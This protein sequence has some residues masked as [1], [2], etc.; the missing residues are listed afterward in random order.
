M[1]LATAVCFAMKYRVIGLDIDGGRVSALSAGKTTIHEKGLERLLRQGLSR[2]L[3]SFSSS[4]EE[5]EDA[6]F[7]FIA[8]GTPGVGDG[9]IDLSQVK[10]AS[11][12]IGDAL[13]TNTQRPVIVLK[14]TVIPGTMSD[15]VKPILE[16][17][18]GKT[19]GIGFGLCSNPEFLREGSAIGDT[20]KPDRII[21]G[22]FDKLSSR[23]MNAL[24]RGFYGKAARIIEVTPEE[25]ELIKYASNSFLATKVSFINFIA[26]MTEQIPGTD[27]KRVAEGMG[28]DPRIGRLFLEAGPG[29]GGSCFPKDV[30]ALTRYSEKRGLDT[31]L[32]ESV[33]GVNDTQ[34]G[35][36]L[37][38]AEARIGPLKE[39]V[40]A[41]LGL[42]FK[43][44]TDD[45]RDSRAIL[46]IKGLLEDGVEVRVYDPVAIDAARRELGENVEYADSAGECIAGADLAITMT[47]WDE[48]KRLKPRDFA[49]LM[50][51]PVLLDARRIYD[52]KKYSH[53][54]TFLA[55][56]RGP[57][58]PR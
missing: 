22:S 38:L 44:G 43:A 46:L 10:S 42:A 54:L 40:V 47:A 15:L 33:T 23:R 58:D 27:V 30:K 6:D 52:P 3:L 31:P 13:R 5:L 29:Y 19:V 45:I 26:R 36:A 17:Q 48:F 20:L 51:T 14:S 28:L 56:G 4:L 57:G 12:S 34:P 1:G 41:V 11:M 37:S 39:K 2:G 16:T 24:Y 9:S 50:R 18:S 55:V 8:V 7:V 32:L 21:I 49:R 25:A 35:H 53:G